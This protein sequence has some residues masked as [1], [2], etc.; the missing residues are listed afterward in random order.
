MDVVRLVEEIKE[1]CQIELEN[2]DVYM[3][4]AFDDFIKATVLKARGGNSAA[5][6]EFTPVTVQVTAKRSVSFATQLFINNKV[7]V[8]SFKSKLIVLILCF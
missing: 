1:Q 7:R 3:A 4:T 8:F 6:L 2:E 5:K